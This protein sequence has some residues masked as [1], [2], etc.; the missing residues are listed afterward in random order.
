MVAHGDQDIRHWYGEI[1]RVL[2]DHPATLEAVRA[3]VGEAIKAGVAGEGRDRLGYVIDQAIARVLRSHPT[4]LEAVRDVLWPR[5][6]AAR[7]CAG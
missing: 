6:S 1:S 2:Y 5:S 7:R 4:A 3:A